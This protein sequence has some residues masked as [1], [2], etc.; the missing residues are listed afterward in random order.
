MFAYVCFAL[1][2]FLSDSHLASIP[3][4]L[5]PLV[6][7][8]DSSETAAATAIVARLPPNHALLYVPRIESTRKQSCWVR[9]LSS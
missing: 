4:Q 2:L 3:R 9:R 8:Y 5:Y 1:L 6:V 7:L